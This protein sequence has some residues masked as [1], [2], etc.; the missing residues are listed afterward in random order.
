MFVSAS[1]VAL[2]KKNCVL[3]KMHFWSEIQLLRVRK[4]SCG[5]LEYLLWSPQT[6]LKI[7]QRPP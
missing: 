7:V 6:R 2:I 4:T 5:G 1:L 3:T